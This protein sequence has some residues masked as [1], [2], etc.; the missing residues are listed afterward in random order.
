M[1]EYYRLD[2]GNNEIE[3]KVIAEDGETEKT[4]TINVFRNKDLAS[5]NIIKD[6]ITLDIGEE[7][8]IYYELDPTDTNDREVTWSVL[9][10]S[11]A[12]INNGT[13]K[14]LKNG[15]TYVYLRSASNP[16]IYD[17]VEIN[18]SLKRITSSVY[19]VWHTDDEPNE[20]A[21]VDFSYVIGIDDKTTI[22]TVIS[23][24]DN[25]IK[26]IKV[27]SSDIEITNYSNFAGTGMII[28][29]VINE[30]EYDQVVVVV[31]GDNGTIEKPGNGII[32]STDYATLS[33]ILA[34]LTLKTPMTSLLYDLNKNKILT[35]TD[36][37]PLSL[38]IAGK[39][40]FTNLNGL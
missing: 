5:I 15:V 9:D 14:A 36:L 20:L 19:E 24:L 26:N 10:D 35:V 16:L 34:G 17:R 4:Y 32:T 1:D 13:V 3:F 25:D 30:K 12:T 6:V 33:S 7:E 37:S 22:D 29:L 31:R 21:E 39:A 8:Y 11:I 40:T 27:Y 23:N 38:F 18:V 28:K 2:Y